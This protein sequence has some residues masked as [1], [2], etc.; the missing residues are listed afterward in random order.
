MEGVGLHELDVMGGT[1][2]EGNLLAG[3]ALIVVTLEDLNAD[4]VAGERWLVH[5]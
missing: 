3:D 1:L 5:G 2:G 4:G